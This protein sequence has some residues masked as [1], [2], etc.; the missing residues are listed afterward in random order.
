MSETRERAGGA[1]PPSWLTWAV[2]GALVAV[3]T[4]ERILADASFLR[5]VLSG[6]G[7]AA[8][9]AAVAW[10]ALSWRRAEG[11]ARAVER[12]FLLAYAGCALGVALF[13][14]A[15]GVGER[16]GV[17]LAD[18][19]SQR[20]LETALTVLGAVLL[21]ASLPPA[22]AAQASAGPAYS[23]GGATVSVDR[24]R[25]TQVALAA[26]T[27]GVAAPFLALTGWI[28]SDRDKTLDVSYFR[29]S[30]PG[31]ASQQIVGA[32]GAPLR[33]LLFFPPTS[34]VT[35]Q[36]RGYFRALGAEG[37][38]VR[39]EEYDR[40]VSPDTAQK[41]GVV[42]DGI[43]ALTAEERTERIAL[44]VT[45]EEARLQ[46]RT[47]DEDVQQSLMRLAR[48]ERTVYLTVG[49]GELNDQ[50][51]ARGTDTLAISSGTFAISTLLGYLNFSERELGVRAGLGNEVPQDAA[52]VLVLGPRR[53]FLEA[54]LRALERYLLRGGSVLFALEPDSDFELGPL[55]DLLGVD[56]RRV[57]LVD[58]QNYV[59]FQDNLS[60]RAIIV[61]DRVFSHASTSTV[62]QGGIGDGMVFMG[63]GY[64][65]PKEAGG[66]GLTV[67]VRSM[68]NAFP[69]S[70]RDYEL[71][72]AEERLQ[73]AIGV[74]VDAPSGP[75]AA[76]A[77]SEMR[78]LVFADSE[79]FS[80]L[81]LTRVGINQALLAD[82]LLWLGREEELAG[83]TASEADVPIVH[84]RAENIA[85]FYSTILG[86]PA[87]VLGLG[88]L[89][90]RRRRARQ[91]E[92]AA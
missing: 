18:A 20:R 43:I 51:S 44:P 15:G 59:R 79:L 29:T 31:T 12:L 9:L 56:Y 65:E 48:T 53:P 11:D 72:G 26:L 40:L 7:M 6:L 66:P 14:L 71:N 69:D 82:A 61:T 2:V 38:N 85:W 70:T 34:D 22:L 3:F 24:L 37:G 8:L 1:A 92:A 4:G 42:R 80:D 5:Y 27:V 86:A 75:Q 67:T 83:E 47:L 36:L 10:R 50:S 13:F 68:P 64:L 28:A 41:Y 76:S 57:P 89:G 91:T 17:A 87:L 58:D 62:S 55:A 81:V 46:L 19:D 33:V 21:C 63:S 23:R 77:S 52:M 25:I 32:L 54:E 30:S 45:L 49:H 90:V 60:D 78:A 39:L 88:L 84:T 74:A 73:Y 35:D 16:L